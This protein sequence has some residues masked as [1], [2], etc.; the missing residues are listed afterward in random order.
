[1][2][3]PIFRRTGKEAGRSS[4]GLFLDA[5]V[6]ATGSLRLPQVARRA[7]AACCADRPRKRRPRRFFLSG[8]SKLE[9][10]H[11]MVCDGSPGE[12]TEPHASETPVNAST[13]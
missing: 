11:R 6:L 4:E 8:C 3:V 13:R 9:P 1:M 12:S 10:E 5:R 2:L 7:A